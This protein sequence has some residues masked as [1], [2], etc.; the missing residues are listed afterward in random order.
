MDE[1]KLEQFMGQCV[2]DLG[3]AINGLMVYL[4]DRLGLYKAMA[5]AGPLEPAELAAR[6][7]TDERH[8]REWLDNQAAGGYVTYDPGT[9]RYELPEEQALALAVEDSPVFLAGG[10]ESIAAAWAGSE[11][12][13]DAFRS[14]R[15]VGWGEHDPRLFTGTA[16]FLGT[17]YRAHLIAD[18]IPALDGVEDKLRAGARVADVGC[19]HGVSTML[20]AQAFPASSFV[21]YDSHGP[22]VEA[23]RKAASE[24]GVADRVSFEVAGAKD[25]PGTGF[26]VI[27]YFDCLHDMG[28]P[29]GAA[30]HAREA[31]APGQR[32]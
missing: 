2:A 5:G 7:G 1:A 25:F 15:G 31:L 19:G 26:D 24:A 28:D 22:S 16:R 23:A 14:G 11:K 20:M 9:G 13:I 17:P 6:S 12:Y 29:V 30:A 18:W 32:R 10:Y 8:V 4:G 21:G 3:A 27:A